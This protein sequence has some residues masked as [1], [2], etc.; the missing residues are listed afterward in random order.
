M[1]SLYTP[2]A[3]NL[4]LKNLRKDQNISIKDMSKNLNYSTATISHIENSKDILNNEKLNVYLNHFKLESSVLLD[5]DIRIYELFNDF[6]SAIEYI[7]E[8][9]IEESYMNIVE[10]L[11]P[12]KNTVLYSVYY[13]VNFIYCMVNYQSISNEVF[14]G[15]LNSIDYFT[16]EQKSIAEIYMGVYYFERKD[17]DQSKLHFDNASFYLSKNSK[18]SGLYHYFIASYYIFTS[19][20]GNSIAHCE[21]AISIFLK[22]HN[23]KRLTNTNIIIGNQHLKSKNYTLALQTNK[24][25]LDLAYKNNDLFS[26]RVALNNIAYIY[27]LNCDFES[28]ID[29]FEKMPESKM[30]A[31]HYCSYVICLAET[32]QNEKGISI[33]EKWTPSTTNAYYKQLFKCYYQNFKKNDYK[34]LS[35]E[36]EKTYYKYQKEIDDFD[37]EFI[38]ILLSYRF[39]KEGNTKKALEYFEKLYQ[40]N[41]SY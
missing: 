24:E 6:I 9:G 20:L 41:Y 12:Y 27:M 22:S 31:S 17:Y 10:Y 40:L 8:D 37:K 39:K 35:K 14:A 29:C 30:Q 7:E 13:L 32:N 1:Y 11:S 25:L 26:Q 23:F 19:D 4:Y 34:K 18:F 5:F 3:Y 28:A 38:F 16:V 15:L 33:C 2:Q 21:Q 36:I